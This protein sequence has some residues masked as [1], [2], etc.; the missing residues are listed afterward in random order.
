[1]AIT[2]YTELQAAVKAWANR[3]DLDAV[4]PDFI[5]L[6]EVRIWA[7]F[8]AKALT[9][10]LSLPY[11]ISASGVTLP[12]DCISVVTLKDTVG[13][14][15]GE[16][17]VVS[18]DRYAELQLQPYIADQS[19]TY[20][21]VTGREVLFLSA[22]TDAG[23]ISGKYLAKEPSLSG[24]VATNYILTNYPDLYLFGSLLELCDYLKDDEG[25]IKYNLRFDKALEQANTQ[26]AYIGE[27]TYRSPRMT[28]V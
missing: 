6:A 17:E 23:T 24:S 22:A 9:Q 4:I 7:S 5:R 26:H 16:V 2:T 27:R 14:R 11:A 15:T 13:T 19:K 10:D 3:T 1:M 20:A 28:V 8:R 21:V 18:Y 12:S 25:A